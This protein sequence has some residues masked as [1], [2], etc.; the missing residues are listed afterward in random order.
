MNDL[1]NYIHSLMHSPLKGCTYVLVLRIF[2]LKITVCQCKAR[3][4]MKDECKCRD[5]QRI[6]SGEIANTIVLR[7][8]NSRERISLNQV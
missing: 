5:G 4:E 3:D 7:V 2:A 6:V 1:T 8:H